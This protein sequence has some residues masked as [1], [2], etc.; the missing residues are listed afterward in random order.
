MLI[1]TEACARA[2]LIGNPSDGYFGRTI[3]FTFSDYKA[4]VT[5]WESPELCILPSVRDHETFDS[6]GSLAKSVRLFGYYG[7]IRLLKAAIKTFYEYVTAHGIHIDRRNFTIRYESTIPG[8][9]GM[10]GSSAIVT[11]T[12]RA[13]MNFYGVS[14]PRP[15]LANVI[16][17]TEEKEL[18]IAAGLQD[19][20][21]QVYGGL[22]YMDF[23]K[24]LLD[25]RGYGEYVPLDP[26]LMPKVY[27]AYRTDLSE[28][29]SVY[30]N[31]LKARYNAGDKAVVNAM[32]FWRDIT[33]EARECLETGD[34]RRLSQLMDANFDKR[35]ELSVI[36]PENL[37]MIRAARSCG[38][39]AKF[40]G[41]GGAIVGIYE[42]DAM[43]D[44]L[45]AELAKIS[46][47][48]IKP[49]LA[50]NADAGVI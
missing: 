36:S 17:S 24:Q 3:S 18:G 9:V 23:D 20:V 49:T 16:R 41:S 13:L 8:L 14:I 50:A 31:N 28:A 1:K 5:L 33:L 10:A 25:S 38:A 4:S 40:T 30:H 39:S 12:Y 29:S 45:E 7:G 19:R 22:V 34:H 21:I 42:D 15:E 11:A 48:V 35:A 26:K 47:K 27:V 6:I 32:A 2:A 43:F 46:V 44:R 37:A